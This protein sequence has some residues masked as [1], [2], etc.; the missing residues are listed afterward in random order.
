MSKFTPHFLQEIGGSPGLAYIVDSSLLESKY[1]GRKFADNLCSSIQNLGYSSSEAI[2][3]SEHLE[4]WVSLGVFWTEL[5]ALEY[6]LSVKAA[7]EC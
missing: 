7:P 5:S 1:N 3:N 2:Q 6:G 4:R